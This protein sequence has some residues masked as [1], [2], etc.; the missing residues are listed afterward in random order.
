MYFT[1][2]YEEYVFHIEFTVYN[3]VIRIS[4]IIM[5]YNSH[6]W[7]TGV[8]LSNLVFEKDFLG[9]WKAISLY[10]YIRW[11]RFELWLKIIIFHEFYE[12]CIFFIEPNEKNGFFSPQVPTVKI[13]VQV[14]DSPYSPIFILRYH[15]KSGSTRNVYVAQ[16]FSTADQNEN[17]LFLFDVTYIT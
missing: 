17:F 14:R 15:L 12:D 1:R 8:W 2:N 6:N 7:K 9:W 10:H 11:N 13:Y 3:S 4:G 16:L 5:E